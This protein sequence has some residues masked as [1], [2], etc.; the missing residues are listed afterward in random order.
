MGLDVY[1][2]GTGGMMPLPNRH[3]TSVLV[4]REGDLFLFDCGE[5][6]QVALRRLNLKW[7]K[8]HSICITHTHADHVTG[9]PGII[10]LSSQVQRSEPLYIYGPPRLREYLETTIE[11]LE[12][13]INYEI[14]IR[15]IPVESQTVVEYDDFSIRAFPLRHTKKCVGY[16]MI[17][18]DR[19]GVFFPEK[20]ETLGVPK[21]PLWATLQRGE[22]VLNSQGNT[23]QPEQV[24][25]DPRKGLKFSFITD[26]MYFP[27]IAPEVT[28]SDLL[29]CE[30]MFT[31]DLIDHATEKRHLT[32]EQ[33]G[34][35]AKSATGVKRMGLIHYSPRFSD[36]ELK[37]LLK[38][39]QAVFAETFLTKER[40]HLTLAYDE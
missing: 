23:I 39:A 27:E 17:E 7:K 5:G 6:T 18:K 34:T 33:A 24:M 2:L 31:K 10:M 30:G 28:N 37:Y 38:E 32:A 40:Q 15:E 3:L 35:I 22:S 21:G 14:I 36:R 29:I 11:S 25:G 13:Y 12:V 8:I 19:P 4:R 1:V 20:A 26:T 9:L 16:S